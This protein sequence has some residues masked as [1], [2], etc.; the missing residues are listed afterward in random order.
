MAYREST[1]RRDRAYLSALR[2]GMT[3]REIARKHNAG[4]RTIYEGIGRARLAEKPAGPEPR[5]PRL[6]PLF[7][8]DSYTP[9]SACPHHGP[10]MPGSVFVCMICHSS[11]AD[12]HPAMRRH[13]SD[14]RPDPRPKV[15]TRPKTRK[16]RRK[17][18]A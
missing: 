9:R 1:Q 14:P 17:A 2:C 7:P 4:V 12:A 10:I 5:Q 8:V 3:V 11:G 13:T 16:E 6:E 15:S 18:V